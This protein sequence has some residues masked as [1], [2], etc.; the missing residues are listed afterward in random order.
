MPMNV[1]GGPRFRLLFPVLAAS[2]A[3]ERLGPLSHRRHLPR[4]EFVLMTMQR[5]VFGG[6]VQFCLAAPPCRSSLS[7]PA[8]PRIAHGGVRPMAAQ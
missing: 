7:M 6:G 8:G 4:S 5:L 3:S 1:T 2:L